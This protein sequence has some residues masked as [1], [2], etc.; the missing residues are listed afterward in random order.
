MAEPISPKPTAEP[1]DPSIVQA[2]L[3]R[4]KTK[5]AAIPPGKTGAIVVG[6]DWKAGVP[7]WGRFGVATK[8]GEHWQLS[9]EAETRFKKAPPNAGIYTAFIW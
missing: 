1:P 9:V 4:L 8:V 2:D 7:V 5:L 3:E 6:L